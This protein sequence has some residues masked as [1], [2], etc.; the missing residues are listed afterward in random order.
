MVHWLFCRQRTYNMYDPE[1]QKS[2]TP[3]R[4]FFEVTDTKLRASDFNHLKSGM[5]I[6]EVEAIVGKA[7]RPLGSTLDFL[8]YN[9]EN[10]ATMVLWYQPN[11]NSNKILQGMYILNRDTSKTILISLKN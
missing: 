2:R 11:Q 5:T 10:D 9:L 6:D 3:P 8:C 7:H 4:S 1:G